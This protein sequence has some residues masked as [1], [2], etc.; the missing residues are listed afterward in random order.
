[1]EPVKITEEEKEAIQ[2]IQSSIQALDEHVQIQLSARGELTHQKNNWW[3]NF[4]EKYEVTDVQILIIT[5]DGVV[6]E[7]QRRG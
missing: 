4:R 2:L 7:K 1:M 5:P 6:Q 3:L